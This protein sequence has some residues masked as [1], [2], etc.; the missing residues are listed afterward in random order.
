MARESEAIAE[1]VEKSLSERRTKQQL[2]KESRQQAQN[3]QQNGSMQPKGTISLISASGKLNQ[4]NLT[5]KF[6]SPVKQKDSHGKLP[7][8]SRY[9]EVSKISEQ[10]ET[11]NKRDG[12]SPDSLNNDE[13]EPFHPDSD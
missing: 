6:S 7:P 1:Q 10:S 12:Q 3:D 9:V 4:I 5:E 8:V 13:E 2:L 11:K